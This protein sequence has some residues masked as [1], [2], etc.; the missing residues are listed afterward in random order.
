M[1]VYI[2]LHELGVCI[3][4]YIVHGSQIVNSYSSFHKLI[5]WV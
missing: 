1:Y 4:M 5:S 2:G 3:S